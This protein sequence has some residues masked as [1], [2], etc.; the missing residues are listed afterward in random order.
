MRKNRIKT[1]NFESCPWDW[2]LNQGECPILVS[3]WHHW[4]IDKLDSFLH[5]ERQQKRS[6]DWIERIKNGWNDDYNHVRQVWEAYDFLMILSHINLFLEKWLQITVIFTFRCHYMHRSAC[7]RSNL[8]KKRESLDGNTAAKVTGPHIA[9]T[10]CKSIILMVMHVLVLADIFIITPTLATKERKR[11]RHFL[12]HRKSLH[13]LY[14][15]APGTE[16]S[17]ETVWW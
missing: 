4:D 10:E 9:F 6:W 2:P 1:L 5:S 17:L 12:Y 13:F 14:Q 11:I 16:F 8:G 7:H 3:R 15:E